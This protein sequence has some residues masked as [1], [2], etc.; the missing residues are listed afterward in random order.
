M[1]NTTFE[2]GEVEP[3][4][5]AAWDKAEAFKPKADPAADAYCI[6]IPPPNVTGVLHIGHALNNTLQDILVRFERLRGKSVLWQPGTDHAGIA[7]QMVVERALIEEGNQDRRAMGREA[8]LERVWAWKGRSEGAIREQ[9]KRLGASCDWSRERFTLDEGLS[10]AVRKVF[11]QLHKEGLIYKD[12]RLVNWDPHFETAVSDLEVES[13][14]VAGHFWHFKYPLENGETYQFPIAHDEQGEPTEWETR[15]YIAIATTRPETMLGDGAVAVHPTDARY[16]GIVGKRVLLPL[17]DR[18]IPIIADEYPDPSFGSGAVKI[19]GAHDF[20]DYQVARRHG[21]SL[22]ELMDTRGRMADVAHVPKKYRGLDRFVARSLIVADIEALGLLDKIEDKKITQPFGDRS[23]VVI[24]PM[25]T[26]QWYVNAPALAGRAVAAVEQGETVITPKQWE[27][28]YFEW[29]RNI[30]PWCVSR[31]LWW[32][33]RIPA[34]YGPDGKVFVA[35]TEAAAVEAARAHYGK[36]VPLTQDEDVLDTWFSSALWPFSTLGWPDKT[37]ELARYYPTTTLVTGFDIIF[38]WVA[39]MLMMGLHFTDQVPFRQVYLNPLVRDASGAKMSKSKGNAMDPLDLIDRF[40]ADAVRFTLAALTTPGRD[41]KLAEPR[42]EGYRNFGTK[43]WNAARF[44]QMNEC[45]LWGAF[46]PKSA[47]D[48]VNRWIVGETHK[49]ASAVTAELEGFRFDDAAATLYRF[50]WNTF[51]DWYLE[52]A[53]PM[54]AGEDEALK[55]ETRHIAAWTLDQILVLLHPFMPFLTEELWARLGDYG[56]KREGLLVNAA[57]PKHDPSL[58]DAAA[59]DEIGWVIE[60]ISA[61][62]ATRAALNVPPAARIPLLVI[63]AEAQASKRLEDRQELIDRLARLEYS[64]TADA[65]PL[66]SVTFVLQ[67]ATVALPLH[68]IVDFAAEAER[69]KKEIAKFEGEIKKTEAKLGNAEF[70]AKAPEEVVE[71][72]RERLEDAKNAK[73]MLSHA[74]AQLQEALAAGRD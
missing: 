19:T 25:L 47:K 5:R 18:L 74:L 44:C 66:G 38:F 1:I 24:E 70:V 35:E 63:G 3:R 62:R 45:A 20:N 26:D 50:V 67:G 60:L 7:T 46:D 49:A 12:K 55:G 4:V 52:L 69:L 13:R 16:A 43:L 51:C 53:K 31:Q 27:K 14:E 32:G 6:V 28:T 36:L 72:N 58:V 17:S 71:E 56:A 42:I 34:W 21:L 40:G 68:G 39:R 9:L 22:Y 8:F 57:W 30:E 29:M 41:L 64:T 11:V 54:L 48:P 15:D 59:E 73:A 65:A 33:H 61:V 2:P 10:A 23:G 37:P